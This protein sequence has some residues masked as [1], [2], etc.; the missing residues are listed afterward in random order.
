MIRFF[1]GGMWTIWVFG[2]PHPNLQ[3]LMLGLLWNPINQALPWLW[4]P[5]LHRG[6][7]MR[8]MNL[9]PIVVA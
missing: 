5:T 4:V 9:E 8:T 3:A 6:D 1:V 7:M 2:Q